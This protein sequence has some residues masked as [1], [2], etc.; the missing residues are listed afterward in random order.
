MFKTTKEIEVFYLQLARFTYPDPSFFESLYQGKIFS[1]QVLE[2]MNTDFQR[3]ERTPLLTR[4][5]EKDMALKQDTF[6]GNS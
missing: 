3:V 2:A 1:A 5:H 4:G 6:V